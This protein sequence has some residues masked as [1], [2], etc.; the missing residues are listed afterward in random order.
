[1]EYQKYAKGF[2]ERFLA[3][4]K[5]AQDSIIPFFFCHCCTWMRSDGIYLMPMRTLT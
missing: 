5:K 1:M 2:W 3:L 4:L